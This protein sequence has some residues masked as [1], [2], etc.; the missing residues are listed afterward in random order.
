MGISCRSSPVAPAKYAL[1]PLP[2]TT[3]LLAAHP[4][5]LQLL[6]LGVCSWGG[7]GPTHGLC[8]CRGAMELG[9]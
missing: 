8:M 9:Y 3:C 1:L 7:M 4:G 5:R 6:L 2:H